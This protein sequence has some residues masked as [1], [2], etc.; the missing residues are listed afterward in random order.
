MLKTINT[1]KTSGSRL[2]NLV[3]DILDAASMRK[4][5]LAVKHEK[6][7]LYKIVED[8]VELTAPLVSCSNEQLRVAGSCMD[9]RRIVVAVVVLTAPLVSCSDEQLRAAAWGMHERLCG[10]CMRDS[11]VGCRTHCFAPY[12]AHQPR[13][14]QFPPIM[15]APCKTLLTSALRASPPYTQTYRL[16]RQGSRC[17][18]R[19]HPSCS[20]H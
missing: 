7:N 20:A 15:H 3:N 4:G 5:K 19:H 14:W 9:I 1:I 12:H 13:P 17:P 8:V 16:P 18:Q 10:V 2:L 6:V 11:S